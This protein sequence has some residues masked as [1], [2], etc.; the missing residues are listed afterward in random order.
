MF[1]YQNVGG[2]CSSISFRF[3]AY[4]IILKKFVLF[5]IKLNIILKYLYANNN[6][7][8]KILLIFYHHLRFVE[9]KN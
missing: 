2:F 5:Y 6:K 3:R 8:N 7:N 4:I 9:T 1:I